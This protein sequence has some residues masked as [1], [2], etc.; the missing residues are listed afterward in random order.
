M[1][2]S[3][4]LILTFLLIVIPISILVAQPPPPPPK[5]IPLDSGV[6]FVVGGG[7]YILLRN[8]LRINKSNK[9]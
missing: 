5:P 7:I 9:E 3:K 8:F 4:A 1:C 2:K 6:G